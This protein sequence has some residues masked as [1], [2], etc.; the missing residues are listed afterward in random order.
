MRTYAELVAL[1]NQPENVYKTEIILNSTTAIFRH[2]VGTGDWRFYIRYRGAHVLDIRS[3]GVFRYSLGNQDTI[4]GRKVAN[5]HGPI[6]LV[7][8]GDVT[9]WTGSH[10]HGALNVF[11]YMDGMTFD[12]N[13]TIRVGRL[14]PYRAPARTSIP[15][16]LRPY[17]ATLDERVKSYIHGYFRWLAGLSTM[18]PASARDCPE[19][20][21]Q[22]AAA[23]AR[24]AVTLPVS[25]EESE[26]TSSSDGVSHLLS[27][28]AEDY[29]VPAI[30]YNA[31]REDGSSDVSDLVYLVE[32]NMRVHRALD[33]SSKPYRRVVEYFD[34]RKIDMLRVLAA[35][36]GSY[37]TLD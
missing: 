37:P 31:G 2:D 35:R 18:P 17:A 14:I 22:E 34:H 12:E 32:E 20:S 29:Y 6:K 27:H 16:S 5:Q 26:P 36:G 11:R 7:R 4:G 28:V 9:C 3:N 21:N 8:R 30:L 33:P 19:C 1:F 15:S 23:P 10:A 25:E 24:R 13:G